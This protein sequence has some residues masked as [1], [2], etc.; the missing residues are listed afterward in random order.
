VIGTRRAAG[1]SVEMTAHA[2]LDSYTY[3]FAVPEVALP[4]KG[5]QSVAVS[6]APQP[7]PV[8]A[9]EYPHLIEMAPNTSSNPPT[10]SVTSSSP[11]SP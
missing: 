2:L 6:T 11:G 3:G 10:A 5:L 1:F 7:H 9:D 8:P 4:F